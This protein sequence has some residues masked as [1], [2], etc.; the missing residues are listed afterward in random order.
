MTRD[1]QEVLT[2]RMPRDLYERVRRLAVEE[3]R[4]MNA[5]ARVALRR[6]VD[7]AD[8]ARQPEGQ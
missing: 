6:Y 3:E 8:A 2:V 1:D 4:S 7:A 5:T